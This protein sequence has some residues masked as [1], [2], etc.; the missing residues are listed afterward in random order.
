MKL[1]K[2]KKFAV[3]CLAL[4]LGVTTLVGCG[5]S[6]HQKQ[7]ESVEIMLETG[8]GESYKLVKTYAETSGYSVY[9]NQTKQE[10]VAVKVAAYA[11]GM[12]LDAFKIAAGPDA[13]FG[14]LLPGTDYRW[15]RNPFYRPYN[16]D[17]TSPFYHPFYDEPLWLV[18][19]TIY[20][21]HGYVFEQG[22]PYLKD[23][24]TMGAQME[25]GQAE[26]VGEFISSNFGL[27][28]G[29]AKKVARLLGN[30]SSLSKSR[31]MT[32]QDLRDFSTEVIGVDLRL[33]H[34]AYEKS[35]QSGDTKLLDK[36]I[37]QAAKHNEISP[38]HARQIMGQLLN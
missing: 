6:R 34:H 29:R 27:S 36:L 3:V 37:E 14:H 38:E 20:R 33:L 4:T 35:A 8:T 12:T 23:L 30:W 22:A 28:Q 10:Y 9:Y 16:P 31:A 2:I 5:K 1:Q 25:A 13:F 26:K 32:P 18:E 15:E 11:E 17:F 24:E 19:V 7:A 21:G